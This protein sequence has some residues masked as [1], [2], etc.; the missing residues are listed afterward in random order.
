MPA[1]RSGCRSATILS[2]SVGA[3]LSRMKRWIG[4]AMR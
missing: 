3:R 2:S 1:E 4:R